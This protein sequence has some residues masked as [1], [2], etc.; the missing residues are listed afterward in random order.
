LTALSGPTVELPD[1]ARPH[2]YALVIGANVG[3]Q[4]Q[5]RLQYAEED[6]KRFS[7]VLRELGS[8]DQ[9]DFRLMLQPS[10]RDVV[11]AVDD[12]A[13]KLKG[14]RDRGEQ[15]VFYFYYSG[16]A[17]ASA[18]NVG[19]DELPIGLLRER[20][21]QLPATLTLVVLDACQSGAFARTK[22]A[23]PAADFSFNSV[24]RL[25]TQGTAVMASSSAQELSQESDELRSSYFTHH[26]V[27]GLRGAADGDGD[28]KITLD[29]AYKY[30]Y[31][32]TLTSTAR[33]QVGS[34][35][36][37][38]QTDLSGR[39]DV[40]LTF[41]G[42]AR[43][44]LALPR[45]LR[46]QVLVTRRGTQAVAAEVQKAAGAFVLLALPAGGYEATVRGPDA[47][48]VR[49]CP[50]GLEESGVHTLDLSQCTVVRD[51]KTKKKGG[52]DELDQWSAEIGLGATFLANG[53]Y[54]DRLR[55][56]GYD[57]QPGLLSIDGPPVRLSLGVSRRFT[58]NFR[59]GLAGATMARDSFRRTFG[60]SRDEFSYYSFGV[61]AVA[62]GDLPI[63]G[64]WLS[65]YAIAGGGVAIAP[66]SLT[67]QPQTGPGTAADRIDVG[68]LLTGSGGVA[69]HI[70]NASFRA[71]GG[72]DFAPT[73]T[74][75]LSETLNVGG[76]FAA[77]VFELRSEP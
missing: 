4:G 64:D 11:A 25:T 61:S 6:A 1:R 26:L 5:E 54:T 63:V 70:R 56:F 67:I 52:Q 31:R 10:G 42:R 35:H 53:A 74:N 18:L 15:A 36:V 43:A 22:G 16:H 12:V 7:A 14:H 33:T 76:P 66:N 77:L 45:D 9:P 57:N 30:A 47:R 65:L 19:P 38:L 3:G 41:P 58:P 44:K 37:T 21:A 34:Q 2:A 28:G 71:Q 49:V 48:E 60:S 72:Y 13:Q 51:T 17:R 62:R 23:E 50:V 8:F 75:K 32:R 29:E 59:I 73:I 68:P 55:E 24:A 69:I 20:L 40:P 39:G 27:V 46:G